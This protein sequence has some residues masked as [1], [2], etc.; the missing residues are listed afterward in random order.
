MKTYIV[1]IVG[2]EGKDTGIT[3]DG[4][5]EDTEN[6]IYSGESLDRLYA[7]VQVDDHGASIVDNG[8]RSVAEAH[9]TWPEALEPGLDHL[10]SGGRAFAKEI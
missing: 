4:D 1:E 3:I 8:Y 9:A 5:F 6:D 10:V 7:I 2:Y